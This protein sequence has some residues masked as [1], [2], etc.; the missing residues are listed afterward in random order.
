MFLAALVA[1]IV[2]LVVVSLMTSPEPAHRLASLF[3]RLQTSS[4]PPSPGAAVSNV[5]KASAMDRPL[6]LVDAL[7]LRTVIADRGW[8][9][10]AEDFTGLAGGFALVIGL[11]AATSWLLGR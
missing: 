4:D 1:G 3:D 6:L 2:A 5:G 7:R 8:R 10:F 9:V 11:V